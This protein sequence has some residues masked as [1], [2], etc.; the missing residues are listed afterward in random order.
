MYV[1][2]TTL[3]FFFSASSSFIFVLAGATTTHR[4]N[5]DNDQELVQPLSLSQQQYRQQSSRHVIRDGR[6]IHSDDSEQDVIFDFRLAYPPYDRKSLDKLLLLPPAQKQQQQ[7]QP[8]NGGKMDID[9]EDDDHDVITKGKEM[10]MAVSEEVVVTGNNHDNGDNDNTSLQNRQSKNKSSSMATNVSNVSVEDDGDT[11]TNDDQDINNVESSM[12]E[13]DTLLFTS[14]D[15]INNDDNADGSI[16]RNEQYEMESNDIMMIDEFFDSNDNTQLDT[17]LDD[18]DKDDDDDVS[19]SDTI[20]SY[21]SFD[22][23]DGLPPKLVRVDESVDEIVFDDVDFDTDDGSSI[24]SSTSNAKSN[25]QSING[26]IEDLSSKVSLE[27]FDNQLDAVADRM[28]TIPDVGHEEEDISSPTIH[29]SSSTT[30][31]TVSISTTTSSTSNAQANRQFVDGLDDLPKLFESVEVPDELDVGADGSSMQEVL[32]GQGIKIL[33]KHVKNVSGG[34]CSRFGWN[35][36]LGS[37]SIPITADSVWKAMPWSNYGSNYGSE[38]EEEDNMSLLDSLL[39]NNDLTDYMAEKTSE[40][41]WLNTKLKS[42]ALVQS[43]KAKNLWN[44]AQRKIVHTRQ[45]LDKIVK[46]FEGNE[47][48]DD[49]YYDETNESFLKSRLLSK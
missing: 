28:S 15:Y 18:Y 33:W 37:G 24:I 43:P 35:K 45:L 16:Q 30:T 49:N 46:L 44:F 12:V 6:L 29:S 21:Q 48:D 1:T 47:E 25:H 38:M 5:D 2:T 26:R 31:S 39:L 22:G 13:D 32:V 27:S 3:I 42:F 20:V 41:R 17:M 8:M 19:S 23:F 34:I 14:P 4:R 36:L 7:Q 11:V 9:L 40:R 10:E